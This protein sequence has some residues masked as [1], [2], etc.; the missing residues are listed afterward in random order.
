MRATEQLHD[1]GQSLWIDDITRD[2]LDS[3][4]L[5]KMIAELSVTG[6]TSNPTIF[7]KAIGKGS[8]YDAAVEPLVRKGLSDEEMFFALALDD[9]SRAADL[10]LPIYKRTAGVDGFVSLEVSPLLAY[11]SAA[12]IAEAKRLY[13]QAGKPNLFIKIPGTKEGLPAIE[14]ATFAGVPVNVT[15]LFSTDDYLA[16]AEAYMRGLEKRVAAGLDPDVRSVASVFISRW[17]RAIVED[18]PDELKNKLGIAIGQQAYR[19]YRQLI[20][21]DRWQRLENSGARPQRLLFAST[22][23]KD[24]RAH[25]TL[26]IEELAAPNTVNTMPEETLRAFADHGKF[27]GVLSADGGD[28]DAVL[29]AHAKAGVDVAALASKLQA[30]GAKAFVASWQDL[31]KSIGAKSKALA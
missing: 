23:S 14:E 26:Y 11:D 1:A 22:S 18:V 27:T 21:S 30:D 9:L 31:L 28:C 12:T 10:F 20:A 29:A 19:A 13:G 5:A 17:D 3:G 4:R 8:D 2:M 7:E 24:K 25:D 6:L 15:L 16:A